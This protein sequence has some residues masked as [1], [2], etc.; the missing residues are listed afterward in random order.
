MELM[1]FKRLKVLSF[2]STMGAVRGENP[3]HHRTGTFPLTFSAPH[4]DTQFVT[5]A[6]QVGLG[7]ALVCITIV[8]IGQFIKLGPWDRS[9]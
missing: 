7:G 1:A 6:P 5:A 4:M 3:L 2:D 8:L 9:L